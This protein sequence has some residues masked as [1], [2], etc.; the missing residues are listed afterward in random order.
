MPLFGSAAD[1]AVAE[2][3]ADAAQEAGTFAGWVNNAAVF[4]HAAL[5]VTPA[6]DVLELIESNLAPAVVG[7]ATAVRRLLAAGSTGAIV[8][9]SS[10]QTQRAVRGA[11]SHATAKAAIEG[12]T[13][14]LAVDYG[15]LGIRA[16]VVALGSV[17]TVGRVAEVAAAVAFLSRTTP[18]S[19]M[20]QCCQSMVG[21]RP[22]VPDPEER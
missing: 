11:L 5:D 2:Q 21:A 15:P 3:A 18:P 8:N 13:R 6:G 4:R 7:S 9:V 16:N 22:G 14:A 19:S 10:H 20:A 1:V 12:L 17:D